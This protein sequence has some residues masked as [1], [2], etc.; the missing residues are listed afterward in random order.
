MWPKPHSHKQH[1]RPFQMP[2]YICHTGD[3]LPLSLNGCPFEWRRPV[4]NTVNILRWFL[5]RLSNSPALFAECFLRKPLSCLRSQT[6]CQ[7]FSCFL[8][9]HSL[10]SPVATF[11]DIWSTG[12]GPVSACEEPCQANLSVISLTSIPM[13]PHTNTTWILLCFASLTTDCWQSQTNLEFIWRLTWV[14]MAAWMSERI[15]MFRH[16]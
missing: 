6:D 8:L 2:V 3:C 11:A 1:V 12:S 15:Q 9:V 5:L 10:I 7:H 14:W 13:C 16:L 4:R